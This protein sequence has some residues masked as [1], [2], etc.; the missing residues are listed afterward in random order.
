MSKK[1]YDDAFIRE[2]ISVVVD[3]TICSMKYK[4]IMLRALEPEDLELLYEWENN[5]IYWTLSNTVAPFSK[6]I[7]KRYLENSHKNI[8]E[9]G[10]LRLDDRPHP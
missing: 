6:F 5:E 1:D 10:Q 9:T 7:L 2:E 3:K 4:D 8:Y